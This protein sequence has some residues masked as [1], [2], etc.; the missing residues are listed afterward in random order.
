MPCGVICH[1]GGFRV[2]THVSNEIPVL[3]RWNVVFSLNSVIDVSINTS[4]FLCI[5]WQL[6]QRWELCN[7]INML[8]FCGMDVSCEQ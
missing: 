6:C 3:Y 4:S 8:I 1:S 7:T 5:L 2:Y